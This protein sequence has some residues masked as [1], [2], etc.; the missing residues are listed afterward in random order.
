[1]FLEI[2]DLNLFFDEKQ[3]LAIDEIQIE[4]GELVTLLGPSGCGKS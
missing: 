3:I 4:K 2:H 1:M